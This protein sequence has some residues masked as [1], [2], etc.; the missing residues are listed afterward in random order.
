MPPRRRENWGAF[1]GPSRFS[2]GSHSA[3]TSF[4]ST[5]KSSSTRIESTSA[6]AHCPTITRYSLLRKD[7]PSVRSVIGC[8][9]KSVSLATNLRSWS[10]DCTCELHRKTDFLFNPLERIS[11]T[12]WRQEN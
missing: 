6:T 12:K 5:A 11:P 7:T 8:R 2:M 1:N 10:M 3:V 9:I 4:R